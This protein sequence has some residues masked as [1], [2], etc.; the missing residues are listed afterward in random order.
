MSKTQ[1][2]V[3]SYREQ[4]KFYGHLGGTEVLRWTAYWVREDLGAN[5]SEFADA[6]ETLGF[7][8]GTALNRWSDMKRNMAGLD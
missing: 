2:I 6:M 1:A 7:K 8:R 3:A 4:E 5:S